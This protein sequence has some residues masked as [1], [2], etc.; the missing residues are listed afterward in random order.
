MAD[1]EDFARIRRLVETDPYMMQWYDRLYTYAEGELTTAVPTYE[2]PSGK[3]QLDVISRVTSNRVT[4]LALV[5][6]VSGDRRFADRAVAELMAVSAFPDWRAKEYLDMTQ[7]AYGVAVG[8]DWLYNYMTETQRNT[9]RDALYNYAV[10]PTVT[11]HKKDWYK[12][13]QGNLNTWCNGMMAMAAL[14]IMD[15]YPEDA[16]TLISDAVTNVQVAIN[17]LTPMG[18]YIE[19]VS[20]YAPGICYLVQMMD[21]MYDTLGTDFGLSEMEGLRETADYL[22]VMNG[23]RYCFNYGDCSSAIIVS[24]CVYW[25]AQRYQMPELA[26][27]ERSHQN[28][29]ISTEDDYL[30][31]LWYDPR[32]VEGV[33]PAQQTDRVLYSDEMESV[34]T[35][36]SFAED[37][38][39]IFA[40][41]KSGRNTSPHSD[42]DIGTFVLEALG[43]RWF[44]D[45]GSDSYGLNGY[46]TQAKET[47]PRW[48]Y[49]RKRTEGQNTLVLK[50][51]TLGGQELSASCQ[52]GTYE[53]AYDGGYA[54]V[55]MTDAYDT[56]GATSV[57]RGMA[58]MDNRSRILLRDEVR[59]STA[60][61]LYW[62]AHT[63]AAVT[64][65]EDGKTAELTIKDKTLLAQIASP[66]N[67][68]FTLMNATPLS[69]SPNPSGQNS[70]SGIQKLTI[71]LTGV[72]SADI[73]VVFTPL[74]GDAGE[75]EQSLPTTAIA[76]FSTLL[77]DYAPGTTLTANAQG[78][79]EIYTAEQFLRFA[80]MVNSG[81]SF[82][83]KTVRLM[84]DIDLGHRTMD[85]IGGASATEGSYGKSFSGTFDG[86]G[87]SIKNLLINKPDSYHVGLFGSIYN[88][89]IQDVGI[90]NGFVFGKRKTA[91]LVGSCRN[92]T[93]SGC[94]SKAKV[95]VSGGQAGG[96]VAWV[97]Q[98]STITNCYHNGMVSNAGEITGGIAGFLPG[99]GT[100]TISNCYHTGA[101]TDTQGSCG[102]VGY[103]TLTSNTDTTDIQ[104][105]N[106]YSTDTLRGST[107][108]DRD[109]VK[110]ENCGE[111]SKEE[112]VQTAITLG[113]SFMYDCTWDNDGYPIFKWQNPVSLP[114]DLVLT[115]ASELRLLAYMVNSGQSDFSGKTARLGNDIDL[116]HR[117]WTPIGG[118]QPELNSGKV[119][120][121]TFDGCGYAV[122]NLR[123]D[124]ERF[125]VGFFGRASGTI[126]NFGIRSGRV[127]AYRIGGGLTGNFSGTMEQCYNMADVDCDIAAGGLSGMMGKVKVTDCFNGGDIKAASYSYA[128]GINA[129]FSS[130]ASGSTVKNCYNTGN[131]SGKNFGGIIG[132]GASGLTDLVVENCYTINSLALTDSSLSSFVNGGG[133]FASGKLQ[134]SS[135]GTGFASCKSEILP[136]SFLYHRGKNTT[137]KTDSSGAY[138]V[139]TAEE[140]YA[141]AY[142][143]NVQKNNFSGKTVLLTA[144]IDLGWQE[145]I[146]VGLDSKFCGTFD[147]QGHRILNLCI[148]EGRQY[149]GLFGQ[150]E[151]ATIRNL[152]VE[153]GMIFGT[154]SV[155]G[156]VGSA[157]KGT[158][159]S[160]CYSK[161][162]VSG[163][164]YVGGVV[165]NVTGSSVVL[166]NVYSTG[167]VSG[168]DSFGG[169]VGYLNSGTSGVK[170]Q[171]SYYAGSASIGLVGKVYSTAT[172]SITD[173]YTL[174]TAEPF[175]S[176]VSLTVSNCVKK[177]PQA[178][179]ASSASLGSAFAEDY[180]TYNNLLPALA[181]EMGS[182]ATSLE[183]VGD[184]YLIQDAQDLRLLSYLVW[185]GQ[186]FSGKTVLLTADIDLENRPFF[187]IGGTDGVET[188]S[189]S[190]TFDGG[191]HRISNLYINSRQCRNTY[192]ALFGRV[193]NA[194]VKNLGLESG[195]VCNPHSF[196]AGLIAQAKTVVI[197]NCYNK[198][199]VRNLDSA[200]GGFLG[201][202]LGN[203]EIYDSYNMGAVSGGPASVGGFIGSGTVD[204]TKLR[205]ENCY[206]Y[207]DFYITDPSGCGAFVGFLNYKVT[208]SKLQ[209]VNCHYAGVP[210]PSSDRINATQRKLVT[211][212]H[213]TGEA[214]KSAYTALGSA[215]AQDRNNHNKGF[216]VLVWENA[217]VC[218]H[219]GLSVENLGD[220]T[221][222]SFC[223]L[224]GWQET[225]AHSYKYKATKNPTAS[226]AGTLTGTCSACSGTTTVTL[227]KL[228]TTDYTKTVTKAATCTESGTD[229]YKW[230][231]TTYGSFSFT[232]TTKA[233]GHTEI[234]DPAVVPTCTAT[235]LTE[236][237]H[238]SVCK[239]VLTAQEVVSATGHTEVVV[240]AV[241][242]TCTATGLTEGKHC[243]VC[244][245]V[246]VA[247]ETLAKLD[248][249][250]TYKA[251]KKPTTS[252][253][254]TL[255]GTCSACSGTTTVT[256]PKLN[257][258]DYTKTVTKAATCTESGTDTYKW[259][260][261]TY[262]SFSFTVTTKA[263]GHTEVT[264]KAVAPTCTATGLTEGKHCSVCSVVL[265][266]QET[267]AV[268]GHKYD[269]GT[270][271]TKPTLT[272]KGIMTYTCAHDSKHSYTEELDVL[273]KSLFFDF[274]NGTQ[275]QDR[276]NNYVY[277]FL[278]FD[279]EAAWR[280]RTS[281]WV[282][283]SRSL[284]TKAGT[285]TVYPGVT[286]Y[287]SIYA[288]SVDFDLNYDPDYAEYFQMRF[289]I[290]GLSGTAAKAS[291]H[292][293]YKSDNTYIAASA[294]SFDVSDLNSGE[295]VIVTGKIKDSVRALEEVRRIG[296]YINGFD[297]ATDMNATV[298]FDYAF[299]G[300]YEELPIKDQLF[301]DF[302][303]TE[304]ERIRYNTKTYGYVQYDD[305][306]E[307]NW[308]YTT[309]K[310]SEIRM[311]NTAGTVTMV[312][313]GTVSASLWPDVYMDTNLGHET[314]N[315]P[316]SFYPG[317]AEY[318]QIRY[319]MKN[320]RYG[321]QVKTVDGV[322]T[323][324]TVN[325]YFRLCFYA[326]G[327]STQ[328]SGTANS[329]KIKEYINADTWAVL[330]LPLNDTFKTAGEIDRL[331]IYFAGIESISETQVGELT[332]DYIFIGKEEDLPT[333]LHTVTF[334]DG[335]GKVLAT[336]TVQH[337]E[338]AT[339][340][341]KTPTKAYD[342]S[343]HYTFAGWDR[344]LSNITAHTVITATYT[345]TAHSY[346]YATV[347]ATNH[348]G[349]CSCGYSRSEAHSHAYKVTKEPTISATGTLTGTCAVCTGT[350][351]VTLPKLSTA[352]YSKSTTKAPTCTAT[353][354][355]KYTWKTTAYGTFSFHVTTA[356]KG[357]TEV[358]DKAVA[359]TCTATGLTEGKHC[360]VC[361]AVLT[362]QEV[363][364]ARGHSYVY[365]KINALTHKVTCENCDYARNAD[366][367]YVEGACICGEPEIKEPIVDA[368]LKL[369]HS[370]NLASDI[371]VNFVVPKTLLAGFDMDTVYVESTIEVYEGNAKVGTKT[372]RLEAVDN[373]YTYYF[374]LNGLTAVQMNNRI[375]SVL[376]GT[377]DGQPYCSN[378]DD[379]AIADYA[380]SQLNKSNTTDKLRALCADLL[381]YGTKAQI[382]KSYRTDAL[383]DRLMTETHRSYLSD[384][385]AV[386]FGNVNE[387]LKD[388]AIAPIAWAG[389]SL[390]LESKVC[391]KFVFR[392][393]GYTGELS[394]LSLHVS[395]EDR[396][397][398]TK[399]LIL[400]ETEVYSQAAQLYSFT[401]DSLLAA[402]LRSVV[403]VQIYAGNT[404]VSSTL[405]YSPDTYGNGKTGTLGELC[406]ALFA[407]SDSAKAYFVN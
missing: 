287:T 157:T 64:I 8:Y 225:Q 220:D 5:Y 81:T 207:S 99:S 400:T 85:P 48:T 349:T 373:G 380:Y 95:E 252:A 132:I 308:Y 304:A 10:K 335:S 80:E 398:E 72:K 245:A 219:D 155:G 281:K 295:Y 102:L 131:V 320:F 299:V 386:T 336:Q 74:T 144:D 283:G 224:C 338:S 180:F 170:I 366:H 201:Q 177:T 378:V 309:A 215:F 158:K 45:L 56:L 401:V 388:L 106:C 343:N 49:Y 270:V 70:N 59:C 100:V 329:G 40:A 36:R 274:D 113:D 235:G 176:S 218:T 122:E 390:N 279:Q 322:Q 183:Q 313:K 381:R 193:E 258:T 301:F 212:T 66:S 65:S 116:L 87:H 147:G 90:E 244:N 382:Y 276:Y 337:G 275:A 342:E 305:P 352:D 396:N 228:N 76:D 73:A 233:K 237:K 160:Q 182:H 293:Y 392:T 12:T 203:V 196:T 169:L 307:I 21:A 54:V 370:L 286:E 96:I 328:L 126:R 32:L 250:Y 174:D 98:N 310:V 57:V 75:K 199:T 223:T 189:F 178:L 368:S 18:S 222:R 312:A 397:G 372:V 254:G 242:P 35:F 159:I 91:G 315:Y 151:G 114:D 31:L 377:K 149:A 4:N 407:Y 316:L 291:V 341:G 195:V 168:A 259:K 243:S 173:C 344:E 356:A 364:P 187:P 161:V 399:T 50:P 63:K 197:R 365:G 217:T 11:T 141:L 272:D 264:D 61:E 191:G 385:E 216:P 232:A 1:E 145:W 108:S 112:L 86:G 119:F 26:I 227:P 123:I 311:D 29:T 340:S 124:G 13:S 24:P 175:G 226:A 127:S 387:D 404:P 200:V 156:L 269:N 292:F 172:G 306:T 82:S 186:S 236:G 107:T 391:L 246:L 55:D 369:S 27:Y 142:A 323:T 247:Q 327:S 273:S 290:T 179:S 38:R 331:R 129:Y 46:F 16:A 105:N 117:Q 42:L 277:N 355:D 39:R 88:A 23:D 253:T 33:E 118:N 376:Y 109:Y 204:T 249:N 67:A 280:G 231:T 284:D 389:K 362:A 103:Y 354:T 120:K 265:T 375:S 3:R 302:T 345:A 221:H 143:V 314:V 285:L 152:G 213:Y 240:S 110:F 167:H 267:V 198:V 360:S 34:A 101:L 166:E 2:V 128:G 395:Y 121:G 317:E 209:V 202:G 282:E 148:T 351:T 289:K 190:G 230:K 62:F 7:L 405:R 14:A 238:C 20:Y 71:H 163:T 194:T 184:Y 17:T 248:H 333:P 229:T 146:P 192:T 162:N 319:K 214:L 135:L 77:Q 288:D 58:L 60:T 361:S 44:E 19:A 325:P 255:T 402:E 303:N 262:G 41:I 69:T 115:T 15:D 154:E 374:T 181:W 318:I 363:I 324:S 22:F 79:Y 234:V 261:T 210:D 326:D 298:T 296:L 406:K 9:V 359:A 52:L 137:L 347:D 239:E 260:T 111:I 403:S 300:P 205:M 104:I 140:L 350:A 185:R 153:D 93:V 6:Y 367:A 394:D 241:A 268:L 384:T 84:A 97:G 136:T 348:R 165:G 339:Y 138:T 171:K 47:D 89:T 188:Y 206:N 68:V 358:M 294:V 130:A 150:T 51:G 266:A 330:T 37:P 383:A 94:Y 321:D 297:A 30:A 357:H 379:Y 263:K 271:T 332:I 353:G 334:E 78:V 256:L 211:A 125:Y 83:G 278:S 134:A 92:S 43:E 139:S 208:G 371:S 251:T 133:T 25:F 164:R 346:T 393:T 257:T 53:S 28:T